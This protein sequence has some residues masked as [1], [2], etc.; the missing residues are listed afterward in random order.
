MRFHPLYIYGHITLKTGISTAEE[1][2]QAVA[3]LEAILD[4]GD[5]ERNAL[6]GTSRDCN[7]S[8]VYVAVLQYTISTIGVDGT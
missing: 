6:Y 2:E 1:T 8:T 4:H 5:D 3:N 7:Y